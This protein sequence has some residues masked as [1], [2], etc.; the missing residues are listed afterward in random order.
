MCFA[1]GE[2]KVRRIRCRWSFVTL[3]K[4]S[5]SKVLVFIGHQMKFNFFAVI[6]SFKLC[7]NSSPVFCFQ[8]CIVVLYIA[9]YIRF[10]ILIL[11]LKLNT[12][13]Y[14]DV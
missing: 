1:T 8:T 11:V 3:Q 10:V 4:T 12:R 2:Q 14:P 5:L 6:L 7:F 13:N 9:I